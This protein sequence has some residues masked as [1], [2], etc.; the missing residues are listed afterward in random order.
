MHTGNSRKPHF[1]EK[2]RTVPVGKDEHDPCVELRQR[3]GDELLAGLGED[4][5]DQPQVERVC[6]QGED[7]GV[8]AGAL[9][10]RLTLARLAAGPLVL[11]GRGHGLHH[12]ARVNIL[13]GLHV[14][15]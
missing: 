12:G 10:E 3:L 8:G 5:A 14:A 2:A 1:S 11:R 6:G 4:G 9:L 7:V 15:E 13:A